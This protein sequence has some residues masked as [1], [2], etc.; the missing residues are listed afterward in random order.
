LKFTV[1]EKRPAISR[2][3]SNST[4]AY[5]PEPTS[6]DIIFFAAR[7]RAASRVSKSASARR[8]QK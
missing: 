2:I 5:D 7:R 1:E 6:R 4:S 8:C 3:D